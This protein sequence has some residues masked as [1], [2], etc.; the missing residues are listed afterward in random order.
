M[1][2]FRTCS[3]SGPVWIGGISK[4]S[5]NIGKTEKVS[6]W[7]GGLEQPNSFGKL[8][9]PVLSKENK[10]LTKPLGLEFLRLKCTEGKLTI[11][12]SRCGRRAAAE[13]RRNTPR[14]RA[15]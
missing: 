9:K 12:Q 10:N 3:Y 11:L 13:A 4:E 15:Q 2:A 6:V 1:C 5:E 7:N 8:L 14:R